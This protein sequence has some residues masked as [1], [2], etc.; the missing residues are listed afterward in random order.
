[1]SIAIRPGG[2]LKKVTDLHVNAWVGRYGGP[3]HSGIAG[4]KIGA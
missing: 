1:M 4:F 3:A 2:N